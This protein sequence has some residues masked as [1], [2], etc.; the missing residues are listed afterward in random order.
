MVKINTSFPHYLRRQAMLYPER[1]AIITT[2]RE[3]TYGELIKRVEGT[4]QFLIKRG[5]SREM[6]VGLCVDRTV[7][8]I[9]GALAVLRAG[10]VYVPVDPEAPAIRRMRLLED[11]SVRLLLAESGVSL[12]LSDTIEQGLLTVEH[13]EPDSFTEVPEI[14]ADQAAYG[15]CT[16]G[17]AGAPKTVIVS[18]GSLMNYATVLKEH[19]MLSETDR[20][21]HTA[22][23]EFSASIR[24]IVGPLAAGATI[25]L[26]TRNEIRDPATLVSRMLTDR[27]TVA[28]M[29][30]SY[31]ALWLE[32]VKVLPQPLRTRLSESLR[33]VFVTGEPLAGALVRS[34]KTTFPNVRL[35]N[36]YGQTET[37]GTV[38]LLEADVSSQDSAPI[39]PPLSPTRFYLLND[40]LQPVDDG[41][42]YVS[43]PCVARC[44]QGRSD[45]TSRCFLPDPFAATSGQIMYRTGD[46]FRRLN[47]D[48]LQFRGRL[49]N[50]VKLHGTRIDL[51][52]VDA[53]LL[54]HTH[55]REA[56]TVLR[57]TKGKDKRLVTF[58]VPS[59]ERVPFEVDKLQG[60]LAH[61]LPQTFIPRI[62][63]L[64]E[65]LPR[66]ASG[67]VDRQTLQIRDISPTVGFPR[68]FSGPQTEIERLTARCWEDT[69]KVEGVGVE[70]EFF[71][72]GGD[73]IQAIEMMWALQKVLPKQIPLGALFFEDSRLEVFAKAIEAR[74]ALIP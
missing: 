12:S 72:L 30:P 44:Y 41:E 59:R 62:I 36:L 38:S 28:D 20:Y 64:I 3:I 42:L 60:F 2:S 50:Q 55:I 33:L 13:L 19:F 24:Q 45:L 25:V 21:L 37:T 74:L 10:G 23:L 7:A 65:E 26:A 52:E 47:G 67:K 32:S 40:S 43:G 71:E 18:H 9:V 11:M 29:V 66:T 17:S 34:F 39:G 27:V 51:D 54:T 69:L 49:D 58:V 48:L 15:I 31:L 8:W 73:S 6:A 70:D 46:R 53:A 68:V 14:L 16:S 57:L 35:F 1:T 5:I 63:V 61:L 56:V 4:A 22:S